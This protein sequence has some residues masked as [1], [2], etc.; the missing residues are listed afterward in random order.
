LHSGAA[1]FKG[2]APWILGKDILDVVVNVVEHDQV[3]CLVPYIHL[4][5][6]DVEE[7]SNNRIDVVIYFHT[8]SPSLIAHV[9]A[10]FLHHKICDHLGLRVL[11]VAEFCKCI[12]CHVC[13]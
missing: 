3:H 2:D 1:V 10:I 11:W 5:T 13:Y 9:V 6:P 7:M 4:T 12:G 8:F